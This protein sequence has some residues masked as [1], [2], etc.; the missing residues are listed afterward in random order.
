MIHG[1]L[2]TYITFEAGRCHKFLIA[3][4]E[5]RLALR[6]RFERLM[7][8]WGGWRLAQ[9]KGLPREL[10]Y[11]DL[12]DRLRGHGSRGRGRGGPSRGGGW[13]R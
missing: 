9:P 12:P 10:A 7:G 3:P 5:W 4:G 6:D 1:C 8:R 13:S 2:L 11:R